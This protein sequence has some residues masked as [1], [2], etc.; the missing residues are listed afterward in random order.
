[1]DGPQK[2]KHAHTHSLFACLMS[3]CN[4]H[5]EIGPLEMSF[6]RVDQPSPTTEPANRTKFYLWKHT[7]LQIHMKISFFAVVQQKINRRERANTH[8]T[9]YTMGLTAV[10]PLRRRGCLFILAACVMIPFTLMMLLIGPGNRKF[11]FK[12]F[13]FFVVAVVIAV[14]MWL[15]CCCLIQTRGTRAPLP[16]GKAFETLYQQKVF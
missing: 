14:A 2:K 16:D 10:S 8:P 6:S 11:N 3:S 5:C 1:M 15:I 12:A 7:I 13:L 4:G 9:K